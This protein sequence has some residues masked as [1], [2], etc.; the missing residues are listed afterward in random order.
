MPYSRYSCSPKN[1]PNAMREGD[2]VWHDK[3][4][5]WFFYYP[6][7]DTIFYT[8]YQIADFLKSRAFDITWAKKIDK[9]PWIHERAG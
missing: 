6:R 2:L 4:L 5:M 7:K 8:F 3:R 9:L 1:I